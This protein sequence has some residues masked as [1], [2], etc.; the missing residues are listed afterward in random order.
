MI[1]TSVKQ[2]LSNPQVPDL[3]ENPVKGRICVEIQLDL[4]STPINI[5]WRNLRV[6]HAMGRLGRL[7]CPT[8]SARN[9]RS[10][11][12]NPSNGS[13]YHPLPEIY[14]Y[15]SL[16]L[17]ADIPFIKMIRDCCGVTTPFFAFSSNCRFN[18]RGCQHCT[19]THGH[20]GTSENG[21][22]DR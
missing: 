1:Y 16:S 17:T 8:I 5:A 18:W 21:R 15:I 13:L 20:Q 7:M 22:F 9:H 14:I 19:I 2:L 10:F 12:V 11:R 3:P 4:N 6:I